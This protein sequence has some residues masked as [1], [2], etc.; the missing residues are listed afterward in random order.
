MFCNANRSNSNADSRLV[1][2]LI[3]KSFGTTELY[4]S[5]KKRHYVL[6]I[7]ESFFRP[8]LVRVSSVS[9][10]HTEMPLFRAVVKLIFCYEVED[11]WQQALM[12]ACRLCDNY[13]SR[14]ENKND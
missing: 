12:Q 11:V 9:Y 7:L 5:M 14:G 4:Y 2:K 1:T 3:L 8:T 6:G 13:S 10:L